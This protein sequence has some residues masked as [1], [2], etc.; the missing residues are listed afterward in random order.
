MAELHERDTY[1][2]KDREAGSGAWIFAV[3]VVVL[4]ALGVWYF[5]SGEP[6]ATVPANDP[7]ATSTMETTPATPS[8]TTP[9][10]PETTAPSTSNEAPAAP[11]PT[12]EAPTTAPA[13]AA[14]AN[15]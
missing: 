4:A 11:A 8:V 12:N 9:A 6:T 1:V 10:A 15:N 14:P 13:P 5:V 2:V 3:I 7:A